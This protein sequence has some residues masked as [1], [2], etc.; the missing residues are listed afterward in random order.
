MQGIWSKSGLVAGAALC[1]LCAAV[2]VTGTRLRSIGD[3]R[4]REVVYLPDARHL[5]PLMLG[6]NNVL[7]DVLWFRAI[8][9]FGDHYESDHTYPWLAHMCEIVTDLDPRAEHVYRF[10]GVIL[11]WEAHQ[12]DAGIHLLE[13]GVH[14]L[15]DSWLLRYQLGMAY[16]FFKHDTAKASEHVAV[17]VTLPGV[18]PVVARLAALL[19]AEHQGATT[20]LEMLKSMREQADSPQLRDVLDQ[21]IREAQAAADIERLGPLVATYRERTGRLP[22]TLADLVATGLLRGVPP[23]PLG[24]H[25]LIDQTTGR[26]SSSTG[27]TPLQLH[28]TPL[29]LRGGPLAE[30]SHP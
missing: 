15:P 18:H 30:D 22:A 27:R 10:A 29:Q 3:R 9:Y 2:G 19:S 24:G 5:R 23:D 16:F 17:A 8:S 26:V 14:N 25:Y 28:R 11:P 1:V 4:E 13:K 21:T 6:W 12:V 20:T 7:A